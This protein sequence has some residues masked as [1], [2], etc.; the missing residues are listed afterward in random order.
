MQGIIDGAENLRGILSFGSP[1]S[2]HLLACAYFGNKMDVPVTGIV[3]T[4]LNVDVL[5]LPHLNMAAKFGAELIFAKTTNA[6]EVIEE[7]KE[8]LSNHYWIPGGGHT[9]EAAKAYELYFDDLFQKE[10]I[11]DKIDCIILPYGTGTTAYGI[12]KATRKHKKGIQVV[13][14]SVSRSKVNCLAAIE[15]L[16]GLQEF[17]NLLIVD[18]FSGKYGQIDKKTQEYRWQFFNDTGLLPDPIYN[19]RAVHYLYEQEL[20]R[21]L[22][23]NTGG[24]LN[25]L[26]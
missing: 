13:G 19:S 12:W 7:H 6:F 1:Y 21:T 23:V 2:S 14:V 18:Q 8:K 4:D 26:L 25:N 9:T 22:I 15:E 20:A 17:P 11:W 16:E 24:M 3:I 5:R 10:T